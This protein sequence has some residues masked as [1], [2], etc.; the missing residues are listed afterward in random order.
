[1]RWKLTCIQGVRLLTADLPKTDALSDMYSRSTLQVRQRKGSLPVAAVG[2]SQNR[3]QRLILVN[4]QQ[5][6]IAKRPT[7][8]REV[9]GNYFNF[10]EKWL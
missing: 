9:P 10:A 7:L 1:M 3:K 6:T 5:L 8:G 2:C 4:G